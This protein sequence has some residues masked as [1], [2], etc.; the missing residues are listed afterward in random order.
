HLSEHMNLMLRSSLNTYNQGRDMKRPFS[1]NRY[2][3]GY[4]GTQ[5]VFKQEI[6]NDFLL[7]YENSISDN[8]E[9]SASVGGNNRTVKRRASNA[10]VTGLVVPGVY[11]LANGKSSPSITTSDSD[12]TV[13]SL[14]GLMTLSYKDQIFVDVTVRNDWSSTL[15]KDNWSFFYPSVNT[16]II[17]SDIF[18][19]N[20]ETFTFLKYRFSYA[21]VGNDTDPY[22]TSKYYNN[23]DFA[24][25]A[26]VPS[27]LYNA[28]LKP[29]ISTSYETGIEA[30]LFNNRLSIDATLYQII[31]DNQVIELALDRNTGYSSMFVNSGSVRNRGIE[32]TVKGK[33]IQ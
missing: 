30:R 31:T 32:L 6:N 19:F 15:P 24:S 17:L 1:I 22:Q 23:S 2:S 4:Y 29:E 20:S 18:D 5:D 26:T 7:S 14:Y 3:E 16:S 11:K 8:F 9:L 33:I 28:D 12:R 25:S 21:Q 13:N 27:T 10:S